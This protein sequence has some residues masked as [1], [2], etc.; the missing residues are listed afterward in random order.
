M[1]NRNS[2]YAKF[3]DISTSHI[4][5]QS[6]SRLTQE[7]EYARMP[8]VD[9]MQTN[10]L[11]R[12]L[13][14]FIYSHEQE[15]HTIFESIKLP[16]YFELKLLYFSDIIPQHPTYKTLTQDISNKGFKNKLKKFILTQVFLSK[17]HFPEGWDN[18]TTFKEVLLFLNNGEEYRSNLFDTLCQLFDSGNIKYQEHELTGCLVLLLQFNTYGSL[19]FIWN[20][21][22]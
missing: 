2:H 19:C 17:Q 6:L 13:L 20:N 22:A 1:S 15:R 12:L 9:I 18:K 3:E 10:D 21:G 11:F 7:P 8:E 16:D 5:R 14:L 4:L